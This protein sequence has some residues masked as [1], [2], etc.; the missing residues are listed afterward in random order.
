MHLFIITIIVM[1]DD[2][3]NHVLELLSFGKKQASFRC[4]VC[5]HVKSV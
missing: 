2:E 1:M 3:S 4:V 5:F